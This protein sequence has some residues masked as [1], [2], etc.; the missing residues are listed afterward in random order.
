[1]GHNVLVTITTVT[2]NSSKTISKAIESVLNQTYPHIEYIIKDGLSSDETVSIAKSYEHLFNKKGYKYTIISSKDDNMYDAL[3]QAISLAS[4]EIIGNVN[5]DDFFEL[6][7]VE[8][9]VKKYKEANFDMA[10]GNLRIISSKKKMIKKAKLKRFVSTRYWNHPTSFFK[11]SVLKTE[12]YACHNMYDDCDLML[13]IRKKNYKVVVLD[14][15]LSNF[16]FGG[17]STKKSI[18]EMKYRIKCRNEVY[19][20]NGYNFL[21]KIDNFFIEL[22]K[23]LF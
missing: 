20:K 6:D 21:Y 7:A 13:R 22:F 15:V 18:S 2:F 14:T 4:G 16:V 19:S 3:N 8:I 23:Y 12:K 1:M 17:M 10:Y 5:A 9:I 11:A